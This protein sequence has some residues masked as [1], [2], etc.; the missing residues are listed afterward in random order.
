MLTTSY[1]AL[2]RSNKQVVELTNTLDLGVL[3][4][5]LLLIIAF[6]IFLI[7]LLM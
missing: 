2:L 7:I 6:N 3:K 5:N 1:D 4:N